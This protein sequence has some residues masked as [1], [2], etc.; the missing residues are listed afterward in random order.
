MLS[1]GQYLQQ[2]YHSQSIIIKSRSDRKEKELQGILMQSQE[3]IMV[4]STA[5]ETVGIELHNERVEAVLHLDVV[6]L[7]LHEQTPLEKFKQVCCRSG[8]EKP[9]SQATRNYNFSLEDIVRRRGGGMD[10]GEDGKLVK[11]NYSPS[12]P[13]SESEILVSVMNITF[14]G[15][16]CVLVRFQELSLQRAHE[17]ATQQVE[18]MNMLCA[19]VSH[20][21][22]TQITGMEINMCRLRDEL[23]PRGL[24]QDEL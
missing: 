13:A 20:T 10:I 15:R 2:R 18:N 3:G 21:M 14:N 19:S 23:E 8:Y 12:K 16:E 7:I 1:L 24:C 9:G 6:G 11:Y 22:K 4:C 17:E 5:R